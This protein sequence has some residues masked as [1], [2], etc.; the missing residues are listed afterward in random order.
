M[1]ESYLIHMAILC[2]IYALLAIS[3]NLT[4]G[5]TGLLNLGHSALFAIGA[6]TT[7]ILYASGWPFF[8]AL[9][10]ACVISA[11]AA[12]VLILLTDHING[13]YFA[14][15]TLAFALIVNSIL[16]NWSS[17]TGGPL[18]LSILQRT[19]FLFEIKS[20]GAFLIF[21]LIIVIICSLVLYR[22]IHSPFGRLLEATRDDELYL[23]GLGK[24]TRLLKCKA[25]MISAVF[26]AIAG[27]LL[28]QYY[29]YI[30]PNIFG[31][32][33]IIFIFTIVIVGGLASFKG[34]IVAT[35][36]IFTIPE[37]IKFLPLSSSTMGPL[38]LILYSIVL[39]GILLYRPKGLFGEVTL[40]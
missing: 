9:I 17:V 25:M 32:A 2:C 20:N 22:I 6:Y 34:S 11:I 18:G 7:S 31:I 4:V 24:N 1:I 16:L 28:A 36:L 13:D 26:A 30:S 29:Q 39:I 27:A 15:A 5:Y 19:P 37:V 33:D 10:V 40:E 3:L 23:R 12:L 38:R 14:L 35:I 21:S 8:V